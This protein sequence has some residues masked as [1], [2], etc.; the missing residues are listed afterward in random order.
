MI[1]SDHDIHSHLKHYKLLDPVSANSVQAASVDLH[2]GQ[3]FAWFKRS[4]TTGVA[5]DPLVADAEKL[6]VRSNQI[7]QFELNPLEFCLGVTLEKVNIPLT[8]AGRLDG[9]SSLARFGLLI[10]CTGGNI[11]PGFSGYVT[12]EIFNC[13]PNTLLLTAGMPIAQLVLQVLNTQ[14]DKPYQGRYQG[15]EGL[16]ASRYSSLPGITEPFTKDIRQK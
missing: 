12:L 8:L 5:V 9:K 11:D 13:S 4:T 15:A 7:D 6:M 16:Q 1:L 2:L 10:H 3:E 14:C